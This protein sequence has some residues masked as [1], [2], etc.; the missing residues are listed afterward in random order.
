[1]HKHTRTCAV[2]PMTRFVCVRALSGRGDKRRAALMSS[3]TRSRAEAALQG[4]RQGAE[5]SY[6]HEAEHPLQGD[7]HLFFW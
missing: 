1:M 6:M 3:P 7:R 5:T 2:H 4:K